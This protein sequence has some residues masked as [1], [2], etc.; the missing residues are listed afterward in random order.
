MRP[1][2]INDHP[3]DGRI[4]AVQSDADCSHAILIDQGNLLPFR[5]GRVGELQHKPV[6]MGGYDDSGNDR[7][8]QVDIDGLLV[9]SGLD[10]DFLNFNRLDGVGGQCQRRHQEDEQIQLRASHE[11]LPQP[12]AR[13]RQVEFVAVT[14]FVLW[15]APMLQS[16][17][18]PCCCDT[19]DN[20]RSTPVPGD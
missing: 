18:Y 6:R 10:V 4:G 12:I 16:A 2:E 19:D 20:P 11:S 14:F 5:H 8:G 9:A 15:F 3:R 13:Y 1:V 7:S 17:S